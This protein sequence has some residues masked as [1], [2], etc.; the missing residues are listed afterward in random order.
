QRACTP[1][2]TERSG[3]PAADGPRPAPCPGS[4]PSAAGSCAQQ[5]GPRRGPRAAAL[6]ASNPFFVAARKLL[7]VL[8]E[9]HCAVGLV[10]DLEE[11]SP[12][13]LLNVLALVQ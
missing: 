9:R 3:T 11:S 10:G 6:Q 1:R 13:S 5:T 7:L 12:L 8:E 4:R 2:G